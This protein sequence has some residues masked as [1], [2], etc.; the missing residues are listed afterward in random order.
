MLI[1]FVHMPAPSAGHAG[2]LDISA[3]S[4]GLVALVSSV[5]RIEWVSPG[6]TPPRRSR[7]AATHDALFRTFAEVNPS[8][9]GLAKFAAV[10]ASPDANL[11]DITEVRGGQRL[12][13][14]LVNPT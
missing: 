7:P 8:P 9:A 2:S 5:I 10:F 13:R 4:A 11:H 6:V 1:G 12:G 14:F 3:L